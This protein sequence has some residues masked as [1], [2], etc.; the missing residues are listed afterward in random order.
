MGGS[1]DATCTERATWVTDYDAVKLLGM[2]LWGTDAR[3]SERTGRFSQLSANS[4][5]SGPPN[6]P[7]G[8][9]R[10]ACPDCIPEYR[11]PSGEQR[12]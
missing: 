10:V 9:P 5:D 2:D 7:L 11:N 6:M 4:V 1:T 8:A 3:H 12:Q